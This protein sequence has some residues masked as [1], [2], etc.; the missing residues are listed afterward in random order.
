MLPAG[1]APEDQPPP[2]CLRSSILSPKTSCAEDRSARHRCGSIRLTYARG[3]SLSELIRYRYNTMA[4][5]TPDG[6]WKWRIIFERGADYEEVL[7]KQLRVNV[8]SF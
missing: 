8:P 7:V 4:H 2:R 1:L 5:E 6:E 3:Q